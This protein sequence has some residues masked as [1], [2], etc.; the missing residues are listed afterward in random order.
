MAALVV[1]A[2]T[3]SFRFPLFVMLAPGYLKVMTRS[4]LLLYTASL[5]RLD[6]LA[7]TSD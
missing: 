1:C 6:P 5:Q 4:T 7:I 3:F 2:C